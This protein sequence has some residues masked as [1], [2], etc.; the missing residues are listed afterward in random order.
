MQNTDAQHTRPSAPDEISSFRGD[1]HFLSNFHPSPVLM[2]GA[3]Y[4]YVENAFQAAKTLDLTQR[5]PFESMNPSEAKRAGRRLQ[6]RDDW[7]EVKPDIMLALVR[8]KFSRTPELA[9]K[10]LATGNAQLIEGN[11]WGDR[12]WGV[13]R[14]K[15]K[16]LLGRIL[17]QVRAE[18]AGE[19][20]S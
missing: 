3:M 8:D 11:T 6:L 2:D 17:M 9:T 16:N 12:I 1:Y 7:E 10:L 18:I 4:P 20:T 13:C 5:I 14:G 15:G 19:S